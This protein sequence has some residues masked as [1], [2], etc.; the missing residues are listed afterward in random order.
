MQT[1]RAILQNIW[2][3]AW[4]YQALLLILSAITSFMLWHFDH[5]TLSVYSVQQ[6]WQSALMPETLWQQV[7][8]PFSGEEHRVILLM[9]LLSSVSLGLFAAV[10][11][12]LGLSRQTT[13]VLVLL[14]NFNPEYNDVRLSLD[15]FQLIIPLWLL[16]LWGLLTYYAHHRLKALGLWTGCWLLGVILEPATLLVGLGFPCCFAVLEHK[17]SK[18]WGM[19][20]LGYA[21]LAGLFVLLLPHTREFVVQWWA[22]L[23]HTKPDA[24]SYFFPL[25]DGRSLSLSALQYYGLALV[26]VLFNWARCAG[27]VIVGLVLVGLRAKVTSVLVP[28]IRYFLWFGL[29]FMALLLSFLWVHMGRW[30]GD[31]AYMPLVMVGLLLTSGAV[32]Y[33]LERMRRLSDVQRLVLFWLG[34]SY[35]LASMMSFGP[36]AGHLREAGLWTHHHLATFEQSALPQKLLYSNSPQ[37]LFYAGVSPLER[38]EHYRLDVLSDDLPSDAL[39][40]YSHYRHAPLPEDFKRFETLAKFTNQ[41]GDQIYALRSSP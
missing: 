21:L 8:H 33:S 15:V 40:L 35:A 24:S 36:S 29:L 39:I 11:L 3:S 26:L 27:L 14:M 5:Q 38:D 17:V 6:L 16:G 20:W 1:W 7:L 2:Q 9:G 30:F 41:H 34:V 22:S 13:L 19:W 23:S 25:G 10:S 12:L 37:A 28:R 4:G 31:L 32:F 18:T